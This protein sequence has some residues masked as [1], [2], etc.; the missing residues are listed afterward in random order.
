MVINDAA[1]VTV[2]N[3]SVRLPNKAIMKVKEE[4]TAIDIVIKR[5]KKTGM[6]VIIAT[7]TSSDDDIFVN[8]AKQ[9]NIEIFRGSLLNKIKRWEDCFQK[10]EIN[11]ALLI[12]G[13]DLSYD[14][15]IAKRAMKKLKSS[16]IFDII[17]SPV[18]TVC[19]FF[20]YAITKEGMKKLFSV[21]SENDTNTDVITKYIEL[22]GLNSEHVPL[23]IHEKNKDMRLT[24]DYKEDLEFFQELYKNIDIDSNG[25]KI[26][27][28]L[29]QNKFITS[30][31]FY[32]QK[33]FLQNQAKF[34]EMVK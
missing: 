27:N 17:K 22:S 15:D 25:E 26:V 28:Y 12:D 13:D 33:E 32:K 2:R 9:H 34:N 8:I 29:S 11:N 1:I 18:E 30:I 3:S 21:A 7:S 6:P 31:N 20:T 19:G 24:L 4:L 5:A 23:L 14:Y 16:S 10:F